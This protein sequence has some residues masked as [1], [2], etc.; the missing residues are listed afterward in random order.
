MP[1]LSQDGLS[2]AIPIVVTVWGS[3][4]QPILRKAPGWTTKP[5]MK[6]VYRRITANGYTPYAPQAKKSP[7]HSRGRGMKTPAQGVARRTR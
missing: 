1:P 5:G 6:W 7:G 2:E 4:A 3:Q